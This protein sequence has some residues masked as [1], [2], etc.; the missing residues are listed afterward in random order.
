MG[1]LSFLT[2]LSS[3]K[4]E[5]SR[6]GLT[7]KGQCQGLLGAASLSGFWC[8]L[9][10]VICKKIRAPQCYPTPT[11]TCDAVTPQTQFSTGQVRAASPIFKLDYPLSKHT[12]NCRDRIVMSRG[13]E[14][15]GEAAG[16]SRPHSPLLWSHRGFHFQR[17]VTLSPSHSGL[18][19]WIVYRFCKRKPTG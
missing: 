16:L 1:P 6:P 15:S 14:H 17:E 5:M 19:Q 3:R 8:D 10:S 7:K 12:Y 18:I 13:V 4:T 9:P 11:P 2:G